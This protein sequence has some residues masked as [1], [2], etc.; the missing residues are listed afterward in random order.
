MTKEEQKVELQTEVRRA[1]KLEEVLDHGLSGKIAYSGGDLTGFSM[2][3]GN[4][5]YLLTLRAR[6]PGGHMVSWVGA[7]NMT[8][9]ILKSE[10]LASQEALEWNKDKYRQD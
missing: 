8:E 7:E 9:V 4:S 10:R 2:K 1:T 5:G 6:F 3:I